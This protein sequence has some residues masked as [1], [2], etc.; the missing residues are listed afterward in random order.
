MTIEDFAATLNEEQLRFLLKHFFI[1][2]ADDDAGML[3]Q[4]HCQRGQLK[5]AVWEA[6]E[7]MNGGT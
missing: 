5:E 3:H 1:A 7:K 6:L 2:T 4:Y